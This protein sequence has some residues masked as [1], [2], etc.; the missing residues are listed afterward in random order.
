MLQF[1]SNFTELVHFI[2]LEQNN[3]QGFRKVKEHHLLIL[4]RCEERQAAGETVALLC[5]RGEGED[6]V[7]EVKHHLDV[8]PF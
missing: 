2:L 5:V 3:Q 4:N 8:V 1:Q 6:P 7:T